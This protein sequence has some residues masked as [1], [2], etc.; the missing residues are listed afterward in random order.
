[1]TQ[2]VQT[3]Q[4]RVVSASQPAGIYMTVTLG[5]PTRELLEGSDA[6]KAAQAV[7]GQAG[8]AARGIVDYPLLYPVNAQGETTQ[9]VALGQEPLHEWRGDYKFT[10]GI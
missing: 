9:A 8:F 2:A 7:C 6:M 3:P 4:R 5:A 1:M 10:T